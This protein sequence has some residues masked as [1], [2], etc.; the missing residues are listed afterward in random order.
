MIRVVGRRN[1]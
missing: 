1:Y